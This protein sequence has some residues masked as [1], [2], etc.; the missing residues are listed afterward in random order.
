[1]RCLGVFLGFGGI[2]ACPKNKAEKPIF[3]RTSRLPTIHRSSKSWFFR[4]LWQRIA[5]PE[6]VFPCF[7]LTS[8]CFLFFE[9]GISRKIKG[10]WKGHGKILEKIIHIDINKLSHLWS[11][12]FSHFPPFSSND[13]AGAGATPAM[14]C[15]VPWLHPRR[16]TRRRVVALRRRVLR[17]VSSRLLFVRGFTKVPGEWVRVVRCDVNTNIHLYLHI[18]TCTLFISIVNLSV[19]RCPPCC[20]FVHVYIPLFI[21]AQFRALESTRG[22]QL[23]S[24]WPRVA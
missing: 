14:G 22:Y 1:M 9:P 3:L 10:K 20:C 19:Y 12:N 15:G 13:A 18:F 4:V 17:R 23:K 5:G 8:V 7:V 11:K 6:H 24:V 2:K 21:L 16:V